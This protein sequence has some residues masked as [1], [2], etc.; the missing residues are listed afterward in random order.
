MTGKRNPTT[1]D[2]MEVT[3]RGKFRDHPRFIGSPKDVVDGMEEWFAGRACDG[4]V[5]SRPRTFLA[6]TRI[7]RG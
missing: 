6:R 4:F 5:K 2:F 3:Q 1:R 7:L